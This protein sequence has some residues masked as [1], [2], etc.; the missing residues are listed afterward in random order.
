MTLGTAR[1]VKVKEGTCVHCG[2]LATRLAVI[3]VGEQSSGQASCCD[4]SECGAKALA[5]AETCAVQLTQS[6]MGTQPKQHSWRW[7]DKIA[8]W[9]RG[10]T[11]GRSL[12]KQLGRQRNK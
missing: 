9:Y 3:P 4:N 8:T 6:L 2:Q 11:G 1:F 10:G 7:Y 5:V 12:G